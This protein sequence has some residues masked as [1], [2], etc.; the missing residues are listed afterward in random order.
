MWSRGSSSDPSEDSRETR[1][2][3]GMWIGSPMDDFDEVDD[4]EEGEREA[5]EEELA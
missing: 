3:V 5:E 2:P 1:R 4:D